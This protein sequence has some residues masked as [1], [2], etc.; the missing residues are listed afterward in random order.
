M[1][2]M[3]RDLIEALARERIELEIVAKFDERRGL[4]RKLRSARPSLVVI[5]LRENESSAAVLPML[6]CVP[7]AKFIAV[8]SDGRDAFGV[9]L[10]IEQIP[11]SDLSPN[12]LIDLIGRSIRRL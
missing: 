10:R 6:T 7:K 1:P 9:E 12:T 3:L 4:V 5:G 2:A 11:L 8:S